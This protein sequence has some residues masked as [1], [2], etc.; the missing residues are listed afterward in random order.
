MDL[1]IET[2]TR[3]Q[4]DDLDARDAIT[5]LHNYKKLEFLD[6][7]KLEKTLE[8][9]YLVCKALLDICDH[10]CCEYGHSHEVD[11]AEEYINEYE[12]R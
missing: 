8:N 10:E 5:I 4:S 9:F 12:R 3:I 2:V 1:H 6:K 7:E 11:I